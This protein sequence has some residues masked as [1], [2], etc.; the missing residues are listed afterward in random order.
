MPFALTVIV[1]VPLSV[2]KVDKSTV[3]RVIDVKSV[4][5]LYT[6]YPETNDPLVTGFVIVT[7]LLLKEIVGAFKIGSG[8]LTFTLA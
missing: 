4:P 7:V 5:F 6:S 1:Y 8:T 2:I 3:A